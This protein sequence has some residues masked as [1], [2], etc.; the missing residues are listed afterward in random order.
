[1]G[2]IFEKRE[3]QR[4]VFH[5][6]IQGFIEPTIP[7]TNRV[8][9]SIWIVDMSAGGLKFISKVEF[10]VSVFEIYQVE[11]RLGNKQLRLFGKIIRKKQIIKG[12]F[13]YSVQFDFDYVKNRGVD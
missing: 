8:K 4:V 1:M 2:R 3:Y 7:Y 12:C 6:P 13:E 10:F 11:T 5:K 9:A